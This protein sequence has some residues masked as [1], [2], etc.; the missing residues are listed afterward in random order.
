M[1]R[2]LIAALTTAL[3]IGT[4]TV[5]TAQATTL[6]HHRHVDQW[7]GPCQGWRLGE[8]VRR[9]TPDRARDH[10]MVRLIRCVFAH[11]DPGQGGYALRI[12]YRESRFAPW[13]YNPSGA[14]GLF[15]HMRA[16]WPGRVRHYIGRHRCERIFLVANCPALSAFD[17][18]ANAIVTARMVKRG[19]WQPWGG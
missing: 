14:E 12:A 1:T 11:W 3:L 15:Q 2:H 17:P 19:G 10:R 8:T 13:A 16:F 5:T 6:T 7:A 9:R 18:L 4:L